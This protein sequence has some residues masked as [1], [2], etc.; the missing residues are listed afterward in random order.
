MMLHMS[1]RRRDASHNRIEVTGI[2]TNDGRGCGSHENFQLLMGN[3]ESWVA[4]S[5]VANG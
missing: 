2:L 1:C 5:L 3:S 4:K